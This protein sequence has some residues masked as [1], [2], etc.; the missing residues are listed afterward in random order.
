MTARFEND[1]ATKLLKNSIVHLMFKILCMVI[2]IAKQYENDFQSV[3]LYCLYNVLEINI[4]YSKKKWFLFADT[5][6]YCK[7]SSGL[8]M[9]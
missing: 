6:L 1:I 7:S 9:E 5:H 8:L 4:Y 3:C 2:P